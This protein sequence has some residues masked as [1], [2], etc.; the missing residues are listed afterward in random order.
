VQDDGGCE[1]LGEG[2]DEVSEGGEVSGEA[3]EAS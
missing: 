3:E 2:S 1:G